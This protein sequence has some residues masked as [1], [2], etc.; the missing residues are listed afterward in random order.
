MRPFHGEQGRARA[1]ARRV[2]L[3]LAGVVVASAADLL[4]AV[5]YLRGPGLAEANPVA[6]SVIA[7]FDSALVLSAYKALTVAICVGLLYRVRARV[8]GELAAWCAVAIL[9]LT[10]V[11]WCRYELALQDASAHTAAVDGSWPAPR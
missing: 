11:Q 3:L 5:A 2:V 8:E 4:A 9:A 1:R 6:A 10:S 7:A